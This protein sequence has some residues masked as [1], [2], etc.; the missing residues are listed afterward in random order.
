MSLTLLSILL[1]SINLDKFATVLTRLKSNFFHLV[2]A[3][4]FVLV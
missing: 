3:L 1:T 2:H 4:A